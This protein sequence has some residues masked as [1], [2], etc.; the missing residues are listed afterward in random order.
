MVDT[1]TKV[2]KKLPFVDFERSYW[3]TVSISMPSFL[4][5]MLNVYRVSPYVSIVDVP[6]R[7]SLSGGDR[8]VKGLCYIVWF[9]SL[10]N[11]CRLEVVNASMNRSGL[12]H[13]DNVP[14]DT[15]N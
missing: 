2:Y 15:Q 3:F 4:V 1:P 5:S 14:K 11:S 12:I 8:S 9:P 7:I 10:T 6:V 13:S